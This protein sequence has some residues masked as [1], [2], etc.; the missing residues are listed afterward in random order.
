MSISIV[1]IGGLRAIIPSQRR[2]AV[3]PKAVQTV[4][5]TAG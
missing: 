5:M 1:K 2:I 3:Q 4:N